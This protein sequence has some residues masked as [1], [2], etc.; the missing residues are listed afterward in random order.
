MGTTSTHRSSAA[1]LRRRW[2]PDPEGLLELWRH[3]GARTRRLFRVFQREDLDYTPLPGTRTVGELMAHMIGA[4]RLTLQ[5]LEDGL[6][7]AAADP[8]PC[9]GEQALAQLDAAQRA[10]FSA[11][12]ALPPEEFDREVAPFGVL[13]TKGVMALGML[14]HELHHRGELQMLAR[15]CGHIP[16]SLYLPVQERT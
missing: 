7:A 4:Y 16:P 11:L 8:A 12:G 15:C 14:K 5:W 3:E 9:D 6:A 2:T 10:L 13:E 1:V